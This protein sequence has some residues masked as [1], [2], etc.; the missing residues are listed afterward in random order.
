MSDLKDRLYFI[1]EGRSVPKGS[2]KA[3]KHVHTGKM[4]VRP[5]N[6]ERLKP[7]CE[8]ITTAALQCK[9]AQGREGRL[10]TGAIGLDVGF[11]FQR[12]ASHYHRGT[13]TLR[14]EAPEWPTATRWGDGDKLLRAVMDALKGSVYADDSQ[15]VRKSAYKVFDDHS[16][17]RVRVGP[18]EPWDVTGAWMT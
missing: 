15:V 4:I 8:A 1:V 7:W 5:N 14:A 6:Q 2:M 11:H 16:F 17:A 9:I 12:P 3:F 18:Q 10:W 13:T